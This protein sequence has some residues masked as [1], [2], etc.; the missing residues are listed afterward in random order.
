MGIEEA[1]Y[2]LSMLND[3]VL[4]EHKAP[5]LQGQQAC[6]VDDTCASACSH[7]PTPAASW[8]H[9]AVHHV[10]LHGDASAAD[11]RSQALWTPPLQGHEGV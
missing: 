8:R 9:P 6:V 2:V 7:C 5:S 4:L 3:M 10:P 11:A 1:L